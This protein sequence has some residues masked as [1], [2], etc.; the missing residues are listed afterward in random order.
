MQTPI[1]SGGTPLLRASASDIAVL[2]H[3]PLALAVIAVFVAIAL[4]HWL[5]HRRQQ[6]AV[7]GPMRA[8]AQ[9]EAQKAIAHLNRTTQEFQFAASSTELLKRLSIVMRQLGVTDGIC[10]E[11]RTT[12]PRRQLAELLDEYQTLALGRTAETGALLLHPSDVSPKSYTY[13]T[14]MELAEHVLNL[15]E[16]IINAQPARGELEAFCDNVQL[17]IARN[18]TRIDESRT[19]ADNLTHA[20]KALGERGFVA[21]TTA[22]RR[23][24]TTARGRITQADSMRV[25]Q[26][27]LSAQ[28]HLDSADAILRWI[29]TEIDELP[30]RRHQLVG[31]VTAFEIRIDGA[32]AALRPAQDSLRRLRRRYNT[33]ALAD[34][35]QPLAT[36]RLA[37]RGLAQQLKKLRDHLDKYEIEEAEETAAALDA[38]LRDISAMPGRIQDHHNMLLRA[39]EQ[40]VVGVTAVTVEVTELT[41]RI[42]ERRGSQRRHATAAGVLQGEIQ[43]ARELVRTNPVEALNGIER[44][45]EAATKLE[46]RSLATHTAAAEQ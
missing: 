32:E 29:R 14:Y 8:R 25:L 42:A 34:V 31:Q 16:R 45:R 27:H 33:D 10:A 15:A 44:I 41:Q 5:W 20:V 19:Q 46:S 40:F 18:R 23:R 9:N 6:A 38:T 3:W 17:A 28:E 37:L 4:A 30:Q 13:D 26:N 21:A 43:S 2:R 7:N 39:A 11:E 1:A 22:L 24:I 12:A 36:A 35:S